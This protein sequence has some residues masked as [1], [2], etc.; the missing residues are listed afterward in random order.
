MIA[1]ALSQAATLRKL[2]TA[3]PPD[4][5]ISSATFCAGLV[6]APTPNWDEPR[7]FTTTF[8]PC[9]AAS[10]AISAPMPLPAPVTRTTFSLSIFDATQLLLDRL[11]HGRA[12]AVYNVCALPVSRKRDIG[13]PRRELP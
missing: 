12:G 4:A 11:P 6:S 7:S 2:G 1:W 8:A 3:S 9:L 10:L 13:R 5:R